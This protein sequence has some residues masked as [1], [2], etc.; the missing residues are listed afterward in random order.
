MRA[1]STGKRI[2]LTDR[3]WC[4][5]NA[6]HRHGP[7]ASSY[8]LDFGKSFGTSEKRAKERLSDLFHEDNT[9]HGGAYLLRPSQQFQTVDSRY[10]HLVYDLAPAGKKALSQAAKWSDR[11][12]P[13]GGPW[14]HKFMISSITASVVLTT[15][16]RADVSY[17]PQARILDR[18]GAQLDS[19]IEY[20]APTSKKMVKKKLCP[21]ALFGLEYHTGAGSR[22]RFF[23]VEADRSTE[24]LTTSAYC[25]KSVTRSFAQYQAYVSTGAYKRHLSLTA[26]L[27]VLQV[28][29]CKKRQEA[30][31]R[32]LGQTA[33]GCDY[34]L[35]KHWEAFSEPTCIPGPE[36]FLLD[37]PWELSKRSSIRIDLFR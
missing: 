31:T 15:I 3:D 25:R 12:G 32:A 27:L 33:Q 6:L 26:P 2:R 28:T 35:F 8:L 18:A 24:P 21:D 36:T 14:W 4:G 22:F 11:S 16:K 1:T 10:N 29:N 30:M 20:L 37:E 13:N 19:M 23:V 34:V 5:L 17:I 7:L 9:A